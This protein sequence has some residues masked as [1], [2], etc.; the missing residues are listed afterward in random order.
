MSI[1]EHCCK[2][3]GWYACILRLRVVRAMCAQIWGKCAVSGE[4]G[5]SQVSFAFGQS[6]PQPLLCVLFNPICNS[7]Q[8]HQYLRPICH[9]SEILVIDRLGGNLLLDRI[10]LSLRQQYCFPEKF[11]CWIRSPSIYGSGMAVDQLCPVRI[12]PHGCMSCPGTSS[13]WP[14]RHQPQS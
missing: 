13:P 3:A 11:H 7:R 14:Q 8:I 1:T 6:L 12:S 5:F 10:I 2:A 4:S 9:W